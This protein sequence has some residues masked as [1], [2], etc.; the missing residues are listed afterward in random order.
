MAKTARKLSLAP[1]RDIPLNKLLLSDRN[2][3]QTGAD[4][5]IDQLAKDI[6]VRGLL[7]SLHVRPMLDANEQET[8]SFEVLGGGRRLR[9]LTLLVK[10]KRL[11]ADHPIPCVVRAAHADTLA[12]E[13][14]LA[15]NAHRLSLH[16]WTNSRPSKLWSTRG[17]SKTKSLSGF[18]FQWP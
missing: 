3:R 8:D 12:E 4:D 16:P 10:Q 2:V 13:D 18:A 11:A 9:A 17:C 6:Q 14:S 15:E 1:S 7:Q 5:S